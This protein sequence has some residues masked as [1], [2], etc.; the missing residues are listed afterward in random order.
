MVCHVFKRTAGRI[1]LIACLGLALGWQQAA[2]AQDKDKQDEPQVRYQL[3]DEKQTVGI[4]ILD[5]GGAKHLTAKEEGDS[6]TTVVR[7]DGK[8]V[9]FGGADGK[10]D[11]KAVPLG[12]DAKGKERL[13]VKTVWT[14]NKIQITQSV[15]I[16]RSKTKRLDACQ[17]SYEIAN[18]DSK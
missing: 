13:G 6:N 9:E 18:L 17:I 5:A 2:P 12:K 15:E 1:A 4:V 10:F 14:Y 3:D 8:D 11:K 16:V 7:V